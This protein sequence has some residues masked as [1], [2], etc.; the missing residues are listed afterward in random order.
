MSMKDKAKGKEIAEQRMSMIAPLLSVSPGESAAR[1]KEE[2]SNQF[3]VSVR[4]LERYLAAYEKDG[5]EALIPKGRDGG[6]F[7]IPEQTKPRSTLRANARN[8][9]SHRFMRCQV[10]VSQG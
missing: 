9:D 3:Q 6:G 8:Q 7:R 5:F 1:K 2:I 10:L 4:T